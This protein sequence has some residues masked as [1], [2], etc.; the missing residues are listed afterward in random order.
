VAGY[1]YGKQDDTTGLTD[2]FFGNSMLLPN[3]DLDP[4]YQKFD[5]SGSYRIHPRLR[6]YLALENAFDQKFEPVAGFPALPRSIRTGVAV[7][8]GGDQRR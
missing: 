7:T 8:L 2:G 3:R 6:W 4:A 5:I 1:F